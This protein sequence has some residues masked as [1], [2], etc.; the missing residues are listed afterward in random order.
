MRDFHIKS[1]DKGVSFRTALQIVLKNVRALSTEFVDLL[2]APGRVLRQ[3]IRATENVPAFERSAMDGYAVRSGDVASSSANNPVFLRVIGDIAAGRP[4]SFNVKSGTAVR[5]MTGATMPAGSD[6]VVMVED[7]WKKSESG[8]LRLTD[9]GEVS[10]EIVAILRAVRRGDN[11]VCIGEDVRRGELILKKG[12]SLKPAD[13]AMLAA[14]GKTR[15]LVSK[16]PVVSVISTGDELLEVSDRIKKGFV[17][18]SNSFA[19]HAMASQAGAVV[20]RLGIVRDDKLQIKRAIGG[21]RKSDIVILSGGVSVG[22]YD[23]VADVLKECGIARRFHKV[24]IKPG[25]PTFF[26]TSGRKLIFGL[27]GYPV[28]SMIAFKLFVEPSIRRMQGLTDVSCDTVHAILTSGITQKK[29]RR[30]FVRGIASLT[31]GCYHVVPAGFQK[32][33]MIKSLVKAN[34]LIEVPEHI[35]RVA[36][37]EKVLVRLLD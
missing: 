4:V 1:S 11:V 32:S 14:L 2:D 19:L 28:S 17:R 13:I 34:C 7:T 16:R 18:D 23:F 24:E 12:A 8:G 6:A 21:A 22:E 36:K 5:I 30:Q 33:S 26:G 31:D 25:R 37:G 15:V 27:P 20:H 9:K 29:G 10:R 3:D 35:E